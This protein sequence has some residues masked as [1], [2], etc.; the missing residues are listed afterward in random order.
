[1]SLGTI[2][3]R[4]VVIE[5]ESLDWLDEAAQ[6]IQ[7][8]RSRLAMFLPRDVHPFGDEPTAGAA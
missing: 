7:Y 3:G 6:E 1:V 2:A 5:T 4:E 8:A